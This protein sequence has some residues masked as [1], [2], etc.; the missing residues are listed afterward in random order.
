MRWWWIDKFTAFES[1]K[2][3]KTVKCISLAEEQIDGYMPSYPVMPHSLVIEGLAQ[4]GGLL[5]GQLSDFRRSVVLAKI[6]KAKF[7]RSPRPGDQLAYTAV[8]ERIEPDGALVCCHVDGRGDTDDSE[9]RLA[10]IDLYFAYFDNREIERGQFIPADFLR[11]M[12]V[13]KLY[14]VAVDSDGNSL[15]IPPHLLEAEAKSLN[16]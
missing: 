16:V 8:L 9:S 2:F 1:G 3:A 14:E 10:E 11:M 12:R 4:T 7:H 13:F 15:P 6:S 5:V